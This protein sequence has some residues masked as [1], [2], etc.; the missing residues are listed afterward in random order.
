MTAPL[1]LTV[2]TIAA[3]EPP[4]TAIIGLCDLADRLDIMT[5]ANVNGFDAIASPGCDRGLLLSR[6][7][8]AMRRTYG[9]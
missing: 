6:F 3:D 4:E 9:G 7:Q 2:E 8:I 5:R 1:V